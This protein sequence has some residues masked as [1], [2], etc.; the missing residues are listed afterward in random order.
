PNCDPERLIVIS[1]RRLRVSASGQI[2][3]HRP[4]EVVVVLL[5]DQWAQ[6]RPSGDLRRPARFRIAWHRLANLKQN[7]CSGLPNSPASMHYFKTRGR[8]IGFIVYPGAQIHARLRAQTQSIM[9][10]LRV[11]AL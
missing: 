4:S 6:D 1:S 8:Y 9:D 11:S 3:H 7:R 5:E 2:A 10:S